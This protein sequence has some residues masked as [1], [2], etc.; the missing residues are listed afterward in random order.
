[1]CKPCVC[2]Y[3]E[4]VQ[5]EQAQEQL[6]HTM[7][8]VPGPSSGPPTVGIGPAQPSNDQSLLWTCTGNGSAFIYRTA[9]NNLLRKVSQLQQHLSGVDARWR[10]EQCP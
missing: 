7:C 6:V 3:E 1:M 5:A 9:D 10:L 4:F 2:R 8:I